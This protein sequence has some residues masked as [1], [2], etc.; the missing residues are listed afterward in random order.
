MK[1]YIKVKSQFL[2]Y[3]ADGTFEEIKENLITN[4]HREYLEVYLPDDTVIYA[5]DFLDNFNELHS[6][7]CE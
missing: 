7:Y 4:L 1:N 6:K 3:Y 5:D 2:N